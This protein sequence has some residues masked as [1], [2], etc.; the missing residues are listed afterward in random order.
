MATQN[1]PAVKT[2]AAPKVKKAPVSLT[3]RIKSQ[4]NAAALRGKISPDELSDLQQH[5]T[6][7]AGLLA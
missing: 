3:E 5:I 2:A 1:T 6:K 7:V 4:I